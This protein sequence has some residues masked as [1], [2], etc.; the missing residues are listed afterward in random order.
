MR[1][2]LSFLIFAAFSCMNCFGQ[3]PTS[4]ADKILGTWLTG[5][6]KGKILITKYG[7][8]YGG[9][10]VWFREPND[11][12]GNPKVDKRNPDESKRKNPTL[13]LS[14]L[15][16]FTYEGKG[17]Y[18]NGTIYDPANGKT[19]SC[20]MTLENNDVLKVRGYVGITMIGRTDTWSRVK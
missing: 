13:G 14:N 15:L 8:K 9:K 6:G 5:E 12:N 11:E 17:K 2:F 10:I 20:V 18:E 1:T 19:Y 7:E 3:S 4:E 16:G